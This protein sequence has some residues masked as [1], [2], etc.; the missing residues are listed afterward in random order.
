MLSGRPDTGRRSALGVPPRLADRHTVRDSSSGY[1]GH[2]R[3]KGVGP[4][5]RQH[6][7]LLANGSTIHVDRADPSIRWALEIDHVTWHGG[8]F[9]AQRDK[10]RDRGARRLGW[11]VDRV[12]DL[13]LADDF[14]AVIDELVGLYRL[15]AA[16]ICGAAA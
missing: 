13:E 15:C 1:F 16:E 9:D 14:D 6:P 10:G 2:S 4:L 7:L 3:P 12:T 11:Q 8:R 5:V